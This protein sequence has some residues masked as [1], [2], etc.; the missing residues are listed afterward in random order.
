[1]VSMCALDCNKYH[2]GFSSCGFP[3][4]KPFFAVTFKAAASGQHALRMSD[5]FSLFLELRMYKRAD[6]WTVGAGGIVMLSSSRHSK[7][8]CDWLGC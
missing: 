2:G 8:G 5:M 6:W 3:P 7:S 1:M 4:V